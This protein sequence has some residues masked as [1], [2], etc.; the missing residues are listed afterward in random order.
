V[1]IIYVESFFSNDKVM[2]RH[3]WSLYSNFSIVLLTTSLSIF[4]FYASSKQLYF[5]GQLFVARNRATIQISIQILSNVLGFA[6]VQVLC[7]LINYATRIWLVSDSV[8]NLNT[9]RFWSDIVTPQMKWDLPK[10]Y[11]SLLAL[12]LL[13]GFIPSA[14]WVGALTPVARTV[15]LSTPIGIPSYGNAS[16]IKEYP[17]EIAQK[18]PTIRSSKGLF[19]YSVGMQ[20]IGDLLSSA[21][22]ANSI[23]GVS[24]RSHSKLDKTFFTYVGRSYGVGASVGLTDD[25]ISSHPGT[26]GYRFFE[27]GYQ[28]SISCIYNQSSTFRLQTQSQLW[29]FSA[30]GMLPDSTAGPEE[31]TYIGHNNDSIVA[32]GVAH[33]A[34]SPG[35]PGFSESPS[36]PQISKRYIAFAAGKTYDFLHQIQCT[37][38]FLPKKFWVSVDLVGRNISIL[39]LS[40]ADDMTPN[41]NLIHTVA[42]QFELIANDETNLYTSVVGSAFNNSISDYRTA[43]AAIGRQPSDR[44][45]N[46]IG[47]ENA[48]TAMADDILVAYASAQLMIGNFSSVVDTAMEV[49]VLILGEKIYIIAAFVFNMLLLLAILA[50]AVRTRGWARLPDMDYADLRHVV[51]ASSAGGSLIAESVDEMQ[52]SEYDKRNLKMIDVTGQVSVRLVD[53]KHGLAL[54]KAD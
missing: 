48:L 47:V 41:Y 51:H 36:V 10:R 18:G 49:G 44:E 7:K 40:D 11:I 39:A 28:P 33:A 2:A 1:E 37:M 30:Y 24:P 16:L 43:Q 35:T 31:S 21:S 46:L 13:F 9:L 15:K 6:Q 26:R 17:S 8:I 25:H 50:E 23:D 45:S 42:R 3:L 4:L 53:C 22:T 14:L 52:E 34:S 5:P 12:F 20:M 27:D 19:T 29:L 54:I 32:I 38:E